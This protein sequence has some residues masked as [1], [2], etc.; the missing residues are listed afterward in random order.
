MIVAPA[1]PVSDATLHVISAGAAKGLVQALQPEFERQHGVA[2]QARFGAVGAMKD[3]LEQGAPC[4]V[5]VLTGSM[6]DNLARQG[7]VQG[8]SIRPLG[9]VHTGIAVPTGSAHPAIADARTLHAALSRASLVFFPDPQ[10]ATAG[11][12]FA[13]VIDALAL[14]EALATRLRPY[15][16][17]AEAMHA[18]AQCGHADAIGCTQASEILYTRGVEL[19]GALPREFELSTVYA[20][21]VCTKAGNDLARTFAQALAGDASRELRRRGGFEP[22]DLARD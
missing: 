18:M 16:N 21:A 19:V 5:L 13:K 1:R 10:R 7:V 6:L 17:G 4:D 14:G 2:L 9:R 22:S 8:E 15:P 20:V 3:A 11:I 12:H